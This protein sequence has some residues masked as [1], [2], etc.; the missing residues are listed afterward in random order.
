MCEAKSFNTFRRCRDAGMLGC[1]HDGRSQ[2]SHVYGVS[3]GTQINVVRCWRVD[4]EVVAAIAP[5]QSA[6]GVR[7]SSLAGLKASLAHGTQHCNPPPRCNAYEAVRH[8]HNTTLAYLP[9]FVVLPRNVF[10][11]AGL[12][13]PKSS[14]TSPCQ[15]FRRCR[16]STLAPQQQ[17]T[18]WSGRLSKTWSLIP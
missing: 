7:M 18:Q 8:A 9:S 14:Q 11:P 3:R 10:R 16:P 6:C 12:H 5:S 13:L 15:D 17:T 1:E 2:Q 4:E